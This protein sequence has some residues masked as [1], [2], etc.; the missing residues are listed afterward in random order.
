MHI[1]T[2][3]RFGKLHSVLAGCLVVACGAVGLWLTF[4]GNGGAHDSPAPVPPTSFSCRGRI[5]PDGGVRALGSPVPDRIAHVCVQEGEWVEARRDLVRLESHA[6][7]QAEKEAADAR[8]AEA[9]ERLRAVTAAAEVQLELANIALEEVRLASRRDIQIQ[10]ANLDAANAKVEYAHGYLERLK[11]RGRDASQ[12]EL[13]KAQTALKV[14]Q[15]EQVAAG[16]LLDKLEKGQSLIL[17]QARAKVRAAEVE[18]DQARAQVPVESLKKQAA[19]AQLQLEQSRIRAPVAGR[20][21][22]ILLREGAVVGGRPILEMADTRCMAVVAEV[23]VMNRSGVQ[24]RQ[25]VRVKSPALG[26]PLTGKVVFI[27][28]TVTRGREFDLDPR[29][30]VDSRVVEVKVHLDRPE[31]AAARIGLQVEV[32]FDDIGTG[33]FSPERRP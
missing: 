29:A 6:A 21:L 4:R 15:A 13:D 8:L 3:R 26:E 2:H 31:P 7:R 32:Y 5:E 10:Q 14:A 9:C 22:R 17:K 24:P 12:P 33:E 19:L 11:E 30:A 20:V 16:A 1:H 28:D 27:S 25:K 23:D 18:R